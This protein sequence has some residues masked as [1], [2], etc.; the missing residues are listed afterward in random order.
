MSII[1]E[2]EI[3]QNSLN[4][5]ITELQQLLSGK[6]TSPSAQSEV[7]QLLQ[8]ISD[9]ADRLQAGYEQVQTLSQ[10]TSRINA[11]V[12]LDDVLNHVY[13]SFQHVIDFDRIG[14]SLVSDDGASAQAYWA[15]SNQPGIHLKKGYKAS[16]TGSSLQAILET[17]KPRII[18]DL[19]AYY[20]QHPQ[21]E[22]TRLIL[23]EGIRSSMTC[24]L[25]IENRPIGFIFFSS[26]RKNTYNDKHISIFQQISGAL[27]IVLEKARLISQL[28]MQ[29]KQLEESNQELKKLNDIKTTFVGVASHDLKNP[30]SHIK[31][32]AAILRDPDLSPEDKQFLIDGIDAQTDYMLQLINDLLDVTEFETGNISLDL[33][34]INLYAFMEESVRANADIAAGKS[35]TVTLRS[36]DDCMVSADK[37]RLRQVTDN[38]LSNAIKY[39]PPETAVI[40]SITQENEFYRV[41]VTDHGAGIPEEELG[42][43]FKYFGRTSSRPTAG[44][45]ST[46]LGLAISRGIIESH[47]GRIGV[48]SKVDKGSTFWF[49]L[50]AA[51]RLYNSA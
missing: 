28:A 19:E 4:N 40:V 33:K 32:A 12:M 13:E 37:N 27:S 43:L 47:S 11:G 48:E 2:S 10:I 3:T 21:S 31:L 23:L 38:L 22:S 50:P 1:R 18:S 45:R 42:K 24:P 15:R 9:L 26:I 8:T 46:G 5:H 16:L 30:L 39:S 34:T 35:I 25:L 6:L 49:S 7:K 20:E 36:F 41:S 51:A 29:K 17:Q 14:F 44:E